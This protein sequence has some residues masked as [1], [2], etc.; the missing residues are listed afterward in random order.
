MCNAFLGTI[1]LIYDLKCE[2]LCV[3]V[4]SNQILTP[5]I[6]LEYLPPRGSLDIDVKPGVTEDNLRNI[7]VDVEASLSCDQRKAVHWI[8]LGDFN[9]PKVPWE[10]ISSPNSDEQKLLEFLCNDLLLTQI[11][12]LPTHKL[13]SILDLIFCSH[14]NKWD[15]KI[16]KRL[17]SDHYPILLTNVDLDYQY[18]RGHAY[19]ISFLNEADFSLHLTL[20]RSFGQEC[21]KLNPDFL[22]TFYRKVF[23]ALNHSLDRKRRK[24][25]EA[26]FYYSSQPSHCLNKLNTAQKHQKNTVECLEKELMILIDM[27]K[28]FLL[29][30]VQKI[31]TNEAFAKL[32]N[33]NDKSFFLR[34]MFYK[35]QVSFECSVRSN[36]F[37]RLFQSVFQSKT[38]IRLT[39]FVCGNEI[40][41]S[42]VQFSLDEFQNYL[43]RVPSSSTPAFDG[44]PPTILSTAAHTLAPFVHLVFT[45]IIHSQFRPEKWKCAYV[46]PIHKKGPRVD[47][48]NYRPILILLRLSLVLE[49]VL[50]LFTYPKI[51]ELLNHRQLGFRAKHSTVT[52][53]LTF[54]HELYLT[55][56]G[57]VEQVVVYLDF[58]KVFDSMDH[59]TLLSMIIHIGFDKDFCEI[60]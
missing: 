25:F 10:S 33:I 11:F 59:S 60:Y 6:I 49:K 48:E 28:Q 21:Y 41:I 51:K 18:A 56:D 16:V 37:N 12:D 9:F 44:I 26:P 5:C 30:S 53:L 55:F 22:S 39:D 43:S 35:N 23:C 38:E 29:N 20:S 27:D 13:G 2:Q 36:L 19:T 57:N 24:H 58:S 42:D 32:K 50:F 15:F 47:V 1:S 14:S 54:L 46:T 17:C 4:L 52:Q 8:L 31:N 45:Y 3:F 7:L 34:Q 40:K